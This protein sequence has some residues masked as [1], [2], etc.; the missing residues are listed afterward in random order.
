MNNISGPLARY[1]DQDLRA[2]AVNE[3]IEMEIK[4]QT[5]KSVKT[6][7]PPMTMVTLGPEEQDSTLLLGRSLWWSRNQWVARRQ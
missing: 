7:Q 3:P 1:L 5:Y 6:L 4:C 2:I